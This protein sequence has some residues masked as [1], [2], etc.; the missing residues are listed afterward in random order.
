MR[1]NHCMKELKAEGKF[2]P[3]CGQRLLNAPSADDT[4]PRPAPPFPANTPR[5]D[6]PPVPPVR[7]A[8][9]EEA[10]QDESDTP[11]AHKRFVLIET[12]LLI[13]AG[14]L[15]LAIVCVLLFNHF[16]ADSGSNAAMV[17]Q[18]A[19]QYLF[20]GVFGKKL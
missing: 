17:A 9:D 10:Y 14:V 5:A 19:K 6:A 2:C 16:R 13:L 1:C 4:P 8:V 15:V 12:I 3:Y 7:Q 11:A 20:A 18:T